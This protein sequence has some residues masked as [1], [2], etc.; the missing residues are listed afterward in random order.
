MT[1]RAIWQWI[2]I[3]LI[4][5]I[6]A[7]FRI[8][9]ARSDALSI[10]ELWHLELS[11]GRGSQH[12]DLPSDVLIHDAPDMTQLSGGRPWYSVW[13]HMTGV[14]HPPLYCLTLRIWRDIFGPSDGVANSLSILCS[15]IAILLMFLIAQRT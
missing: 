14:V 11:T 7:G 15:V 9:E 3:G 1:T 4:L 5:L 10:D 2:V 12:A 13:T 6:G 8:A